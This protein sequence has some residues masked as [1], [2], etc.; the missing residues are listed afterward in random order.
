VHPFDFTVNIT[1]GEYYYEWDGETE[2]ENNVFFITTVP[3]H[4]R[5]FPNGDVSG[6]SYPNTLID[7]TAER[8]VEWSL[9]PIVTPPECV[10]VV[11]AG[12]P[13]LPDG[14]VGIA[15][16]YSF[17]ITGTAPFVLSNITKPSWLSI[18]IDQVNKLVIF[19]GTPDVDGTG[20]EVSLDINNCSS[21]SANFSNTIIIAEPP[22]PQV[23]ISWS[24]D[25]QGGGNG[26][27][28]IWVNGVEKVYT[29]SNN[30]GSI[31]VN[32]GDAIQGIVSG[33]NGHV[34][35]LSAFDGSTEL[36]FGSGNATQTYSFTAIEGHGYAI[37]G[38]V[39]G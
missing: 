12:S 31:L 16:T 5:P 14:E 37:L 28:R 38:T 1:A 18:T 6:S 20:I 10:N 23:S 3:S 26:T 22:V 32:A 9:G 30:S 25:E 24:Y 21:G 8:E 4:N 29:T 27:F 36:F 33:Q 13:S 35:D 17:A 15:Y 7:F 11:I 2:T 34:K 39:T 19:N